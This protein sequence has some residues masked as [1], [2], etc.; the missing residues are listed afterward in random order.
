MKIEHLE[1][2]R[3]RRRAEYPPLSA[4]ADA[5]VHQAAGN[6]EPMREYLAACQAVKDRYPKPADRG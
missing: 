5:L 2:Y 4:L 3:Q 1:D 6:P